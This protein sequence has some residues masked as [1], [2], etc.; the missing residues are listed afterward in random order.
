[1]A[2]GLPKV[3]SYVHVGDALVNTADLT[4]DQRRQMG[5][6][7]KS[8]YLTALFRGKAVFREE[9]VLTS[10]NNARAVANQTG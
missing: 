6:W 4:E 8:T 10:C 5:T 3:V 2:K 9:K 1:M 7:L